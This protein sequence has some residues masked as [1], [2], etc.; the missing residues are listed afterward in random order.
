MKPYLKG[1]KNKCRC[2]A[3]ATGIKEVHTNT[4]GD[5]REQRIVASNCK[6]CGLH[7]VADDHR[8]TLTPEYQDTI[9]SFS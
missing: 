4:K 5:I 1:V 8:D 7:Y 9:Q 6:E 3:T 2:G